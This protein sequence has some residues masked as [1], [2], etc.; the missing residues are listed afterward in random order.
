MGGTELWQCDPD[1][2]KSALGGYAYDHVF[3]QDKGTKDVYNGVVA[4]IVSKSLEGFSGTVLCYG[5]T[6]SGNQ[7]SCSD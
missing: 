1:T 3:G 2:R 4:P 5:Q 6:A 7:S